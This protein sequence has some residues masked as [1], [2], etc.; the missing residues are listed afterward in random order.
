MMAHDLELREKTA[1]DIVS[2]KVK[3]IKILTGGDEKK[4]SAYGSALMSL[5]SNKNLI[6]CNIESVLD[7]GF[8]IVQAGLNPNPLFNEAYVVPFKGNAQLQV[9][10]KGYVT[11][12]YRAGWVVKTRIVYRCDEFSM[13]MGGFD[14]QFHHV[15]ALDKQKNTDP[16]W[17]FANVLGVIVMAKDSLGNIFKQYVPNSKIEQI[18]LKSQNQKDN[19][20][21]SYIWAEWSEEMIAGKA[22]KYVLKRL[23]ISDNIMEVIQAE[24]QFETG[25][26]IEATPAKKEEL[27]SMN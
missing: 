5:S 10:V 19:S 13:D 18:R 22:V 25:R 2:Q 15:P 11:L 16:V 14:E 7:V 1:K 3:Q 24:E 23:P 9:G 26:T 20:K 27:P 21:Y 12:A 4:A 17:V 6:D 8:Q